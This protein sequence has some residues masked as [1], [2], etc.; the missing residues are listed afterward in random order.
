M[1][2]P[3]QRTFDYSPIALRSLT[4]HKVAPPTIYFTDKKKQASKAACR[5][6]ELWYTNDMTAIE[7]TEHDRK[8]Y[9]YWE[10]I[11]D[12]MPDDIVESTVV[13][14]KKFNALNELAK[15]EQAYRA[16]G[17]ELWYTKT[18]T[19][20][21]NYP[22]MSYCMYENT[23]HALNQICNDLGD[24]LD[25]QITIEEYRKDRSSRQE[26]E[27]FDRIK[28]MCEDVLRLIENLSNV[29]DDDEDDI[30][31]FVGKDDEIVPA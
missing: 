11:F 13:M 1:K 25:D 4:R 27:A 21:S 24:A 9:A 10:R 23:V 17:M 15:E 3:K 19:T 2:K 31:E 18:T 22:N 8:F 5:S 29:E 26:A 20:M 28:Y 12:S 16:A 30:N 6:R 7:L 14:I